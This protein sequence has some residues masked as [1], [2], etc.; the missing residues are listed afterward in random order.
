MGK[1]Y[2]ILEI[3]GIKG[4]ARA[5]ALFDT[6][7]SRTFM[8]TEIAE[9]IGY[10]RFPESREVL[11]AAKEKKLKVVG[12]AFFETEIEGCKIPWAPAY[13]SPELIE[14][15]IVGIDLM[16]AHSIRVDPK[17]GKIDVSEF[18]ELTI[19]SFR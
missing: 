13:V 8:H 7:A 12:M 9:K 14:D 6:G 3:T 10:S 17:T 2:R 11:T 16:E 5:K 19:L 15:M 1:V 4:S 18:V